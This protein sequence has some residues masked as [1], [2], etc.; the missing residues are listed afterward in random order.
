MPAHDRS[1][2]N[3]NGES[4][5]IDLASSSVA[6]ELATVNWLLGERLSDAT[7]DLIRENVA[8]RV[9]DPYSDMFNGSRP[10]NGWTRV[11]SNWNSV[12]LA[13]VTGAA[14]AQLDSAEDRARFIVAAE[15]YSRNFL[16]GFTADGYCSEG[17]GYWNY[18]FGHY[19]L[20]GETVRQ[21]TSGGVDLLA[22]PD[23]LAPARFGA[24]ISDHEWVRPPSRTLRGA[25][26]RPGSCTSSSVLGGL[27]AMMR[28]T[29]PTRMVIFLGRPVLLSECRLAGPG[30]PSGAGPGLRTWCEN[31][32]ILVAR[33]AEGAQCRLGVALKGGHNAE[34]HNHNDVGSYVV[35]IGSREVLLDPGSEVYTART[36]S[37]RRYESNLLNSFGHPVPVVAGQLQRTGKEARAEVLAT[38]FAM[39]PM[40]H[41]RP[42][43]GL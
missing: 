33:P 27:P 11:T 25:R 42:A 8:K 1:L 28:W 32:G 22:R 43:L 6:W 18:G 21:A 41:A 36:F 31:A 9:L 26:P 35:V 3:F 24:S 23:A 10:A 30:A 17:L 12:C 39:R 34:H 5:D 20:L 15:R 19:V 13:G 4:V 40:R 29:W 7:R 14:L 2:T 38:E 16:A 37:A